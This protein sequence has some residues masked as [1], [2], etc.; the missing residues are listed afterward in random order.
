[1]NTPSVSTA[2]ALSGRGSAPAGSIWHRQYWKLRG[3]GRRALRDWTM[4]RRLRH[5]RREALAAER[6]RPGCLDLDGYRIH[7]D[8]LLSLYMEYKHIFAWGIYDFRPQTAEPLVLDCGSHIGLSVLRFK[9]LAPAGR[10]IAFEPDAGVRSLLQRNIDDNGLAGVQVVPAA[11]AGQRGMSCFVADGADGGRLALE[12]SAPPSSHSVRTVLLSDYLDEPVEL[13]KLNIEGAEWE[14]L[15]EAAHKLHRVRHLVVEYHGF[16]ECGQHLHGIL[17][18]L[19]ACGFRYL[20]H[21]FDYETNGAVRPPFRVTGQTRF[22][23]LIAAT[24]LWERSSPVVNERP[25]ETPGANEAAP[26]PLSRQFGLD[27]GLPIDR[28]YIEDFLHTWRDD[29]RGR[30]LEVGGD[31]YTRRFGGSRVAEHDVLS[32]VD[33]P[34]TTIVGDLT[35]AATLPEAAYDCFILTQTLPFIFDVSAALRSAWRALKPGGVLLLTVPG[36]S[37]VSQYDSERWGDYWRFTPQAVQRLLTGPFAA[38]EVALRTYGNVRSAAALLEGRAA[39]ELRPIELEH[40][41]PDYPVIVA[42]RASKAC[43]D[44]VSGDLPRAWDAAARHLD[45]YPVA[46]ER[47]RYAVGIQP[48][49][50]LPKDAHILEAGCGSGRLLR[51][52]A[53]LGYK[54]LAGLEI[55]PQRLE[56]IRQR[57]PAGARLVCDADIPFEPASFDAVVSTG[58]IE[59]VHDPRGWLARLAEVLRPGGILSLTSDTYMWRWLQQLGWYRSAQPLD[60]ALWP[61]TLIRWARQAGL[62]LTACGGFYNTPEQRRFLLREVARR[63]PGGRRWRW[64]LSRG[65]GGAEVPAGEVAAIRAALAELPAQMRFGRWW[66]VWSY[67]SFYWFRKNAK[68]RRDRRAADAPWARE[69]QL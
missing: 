2:P 8:D 37:Q 61:G 19:D 23:L 4:A 47:F 14:V 6:F 10:V 49:L 51:T 22:C 31:E 34:S 45:E 54:Q 65:D 62:D 68:S 64:Y 58:V 28:H 24:R 41:D 13:L 52:L 12:G 55:S 63:C 7:Y 29:I 26:T 18:L 50:E 32:L 3:R 53:D 42:A 46:T 15:R 5:L 60:R 9:R 40:V 17:A 33:T 48:L 66:C 57:G 36:I 38:A 35:R 27:R 21:H 20:L 11:V 43:E 67:E 25:A 44:P 59:H 56:Y 69:A 16:P 30:V 39:H 1:M